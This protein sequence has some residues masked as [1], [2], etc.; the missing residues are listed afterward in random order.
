MNPRISTCELCQTP[1][2]VMGEVTVPMV[3][4]G[5][6]LDVLD[7]LYELRYERKWADGANR[8]RLEE[9]DCTIA[10]VREALRAMEGDAAVNPNNS[11]TG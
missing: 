10:T 9:L 6:L 8:K 7:L 3:S 5:V 11:T 2:K 1:V 4:Y